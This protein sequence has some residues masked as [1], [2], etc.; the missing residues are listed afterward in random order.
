[1]TIK[2]EQIHSEPTMAGPARW[3]QCGNECHPPATVAGDPSG[4][5]GYDPVAAAALRRVQVPVRRGE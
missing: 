1:M 4:R 5:I 2:P 3:K